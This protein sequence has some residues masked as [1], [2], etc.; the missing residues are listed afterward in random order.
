VSRAGGDR[1]RQ[2]SP[3]KEIENMKFLPL[4]L[5][6]ML[7][8]RGR[9]LLMLLQMISAFMLFGLL[10]GFNGGVKELI[11]NAD[12]SRLYVASAVAVGDPLPVSLLPQIEGVPGVELVALRQGFG[13]TYQK[14][15]QF[16]GGV[17]VEPEKFFRL[18]AGDIVTSK[19]HVAA[20]A[21]TRNGA[22]IGVDAMKQY[23]LKIGDRLIL[24]SPMQRADG[25]PAWEFDI[26]GS[27]DTPKNPG[28]AGQVMVNYSYINEGRRTGRDTVL[29]YVAKIKDP[30]QATEV[31]LRIDNLFAN[32]PH[33]TRT[34][35]ESELAQGQLQRLG[36]IDF[37]V[38]GVVAAVF[39]A[40]LLATGALM[41]QNVRER[42][43]ELAIL[44]T[45]GF[46]DERVMAIIL[47]ESIVFCLLAAAVGLALASLIL[48]L[49]KQLGVTLQMPGYVAAIGAGF[50]VVLAL[51]GGAAPA[52]RGLKLKVVDALADV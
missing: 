25:N 4:I 40:L 51:T 33:E 50:A 21:N 3:Q 36:D 39:F 19:E 46:T 30:Q 28:S 23:G 35:N 45:L 18:Y 29:V 41:M 47:I 26:V 13:G 38:N 16:I 22:V 1:S 43:P 34:Q 42:L 6:G 8:K 11:R 7:R 32:S 20:L 31:G 12:A 17:A 27:Y 52:W 37:I 10:Q 14:P 9:A 15:D 24:R 48:P 5:A 44:K 49:A 2:I